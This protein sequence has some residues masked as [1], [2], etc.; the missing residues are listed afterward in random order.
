MGT[1]AAAGDWRAIPIEGGD[2]MCASR[3]RELRARGKKKEVAG[4]Q[5]PRGARAMRTGEVFTGRRVCSCNERRVGGTFVRLQN[6]LVYEMRM[7]AEVVKINYWEFP[8]GMAIR[9]GFSGRGS[10]SV[11]DMYCLLL[12]RLVYRVWMFCL[13]QD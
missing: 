11:R 3:A 1:T 10:F 12:L 7:L 4:E 13:S 2:T 5:E 6:S 8:G 9:V